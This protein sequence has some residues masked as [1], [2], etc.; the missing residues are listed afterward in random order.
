[1]T[2]H[3][4]GFSFHLES[5]PTEPSPPLPERK[6]ESRHPIDGLLEDQRIILD[7]FSDARDAGI[8]TREGR[9]ILRAVRERLTSYLL[10]GDRLLY[11]PLRQMACANPR[12]REAMGRPAE[13]VQ[14]ADQVAAF[15]ACLSDVPPAGFNRQWGRLYLTLIKRFRNEHMLLFPALLRSG[16][17]DHIKL[18]SDPNEP[19]HSGVVPAAGASSSVPADAG[20][21]PAVGAIGA[22]RVPKEA[23]ALAAVPDPDP[24]ESGVVLGEL[25]AGDRIVLN[26]RGKANF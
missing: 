12:L 18:P 6:G 22:P 2:K 23:A 4:H 25:R 11:P 5:L 14:L 21:A 8:T 7:A 3:N 13:H 10:I 15:F 26:R 1:M 16:R 24:T 20:M 9:R 17:A 19:L